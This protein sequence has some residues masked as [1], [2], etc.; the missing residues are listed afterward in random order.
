MTAGRPPKPIG[1]H[2]AS[3]TFRPHRHADRVEVKPGSPP[4]PDWLEG[5]A[6]DFWNQAVPM[7]EDMGVVAEIDAAMLGGLC[8]N[9]SNW[10]KEQQAYDAGDGHIYRLSCAWKMFDSVASKFGF[11]PSDRAKLSV[12]SNGDDDELAEFLKLVP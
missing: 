6:L 12:S 5:D 10:R 2:K 4:P 3:G 1:A 7:L 11:T 9:W 8:C